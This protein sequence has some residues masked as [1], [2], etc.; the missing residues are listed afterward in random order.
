MKKV[1]LTT[2]LVIVF[3]SLTAISCKNA[4]KENTHNDATHSEM[5]PDK[6][7]KSK[8][9][10]DSN[11]QNS[12]AQKVL[13]DYMALKNALVETDKDKAT[14]AGQKLMNTLSKF[15]AS[16]YTA[17]QQ[18]ELKDIIADAKEHAEHMVEVQWITNANTLK[19]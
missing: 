15:D 9:K 8:D 7:N 2:I 19:Y 11:T 13:A 14:K 18:K 3:I 10:M 1:R 6:M 4:K 12:D 16:S 17:E 5:N